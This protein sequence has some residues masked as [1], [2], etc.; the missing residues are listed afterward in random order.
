MKQAKRSGGP[1]T[2]QGKARSSKNA[3]SH[4]LTSVA[5]SNPN[6][7]AL[8]DSYAQG[9]NGLLQARVPIGAV[10]DSANCHVPSQS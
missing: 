10:A 3:T 8:V 1:K 4:G 6:E 2:L 5:P 9:A 7:K